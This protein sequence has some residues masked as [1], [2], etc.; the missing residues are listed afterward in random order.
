M[1]NDTIA[2]IARAANATVLRG[3]PSTV[4]KGSFT[5]TRTPLVGGLFIAIRG[6]N[7]NGNQFAAKAATLGAA[8]VLVDDSDVLDSVPHNAA[9]LWVPNTREAYLSLAAH[10]RQK[11]TDTTVFGITGSVGKSTTKE[12]LAHVLRHGANWN[13]HKAKGSFNN[14][15][16]LS[17]TILHASAEHRAAVLELGTNN[18]GEIGRLAD[19]ARPDIAILTCAAESHL[20]A[21]KTVEN[22]ARE[23]A[24]IFAF[25]TKENISILNADSPFFEYWRSSTNGRVISFGCGETADLRARQV[26]LDADGCAK[27]LLR[28]KNDLVECHLKVAGAHQVPNALGVAAAAL[29]GGLSL[30][31]IAHALS[32]FEGIERR[33]NVSRAQGVTLIDDAYNANPASFRAALDT[34]QAMNQKSGQRLFVIAGDMLELGESADAQ[35]RELGRRL[36]S[37]SLDGLVTVGD[38]AHRAGLAAIESGLPRVC[39]NHCYSPE[40]AALSLRPSLREGDVVLVKGSHSVNL[41]RCCRLLSA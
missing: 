10:H 18:P 25:Q 40:E 29:A 20:E 28:W 9:V 30:R 35:H 37:C 21:F 7:F 6:E 22:V 3:N 23:K 31:N 34:L 38:L 16:G 33:F 17:H 1:L 5:D 4:I 27:F 8:A 15:V 13:V 24:Q 36:A 39:W 19:V 26:V 32:T 14:E 41:D 12:M 11:L 2:T